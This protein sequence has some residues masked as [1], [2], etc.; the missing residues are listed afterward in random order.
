MSEVAVWYVVHA[1]STLHQEWSH[2]IGR[3]QIQLY[4][5]CAD[6]AIMHD[7][8]DLCHKQGAAQIDHAATYVVAWSPALAGSHIISTRSAG[9]HQL[10]TVQATSW[11]LRLS[12]RCPGS[13]APHTAAPVLRR[14]SR[15]PSQ[16][17]RCLLGWHIQCRH[18][19]QTSLHA[20][21]H[22]W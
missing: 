17:A 11:C 22:G 19:R 14:G 18:I 20:S 10:C 13:T 12:C 15:G 1:S 4:V 8:G 6:I 16:G 7:F 21:V 9:A 5:C 2:C 3:H